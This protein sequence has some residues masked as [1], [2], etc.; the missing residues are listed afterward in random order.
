MN[1]TNLTCRLCGFRLSDL[2]ANLLLDKRFPGLFCPVCCH[3]LV[4]AFTHPPVF[5]DDFLNDFIIWDPAPEAA[6]AQPYPIVAGE[7]L[8][9]YVQG[10]RWNP[11]TELC[12]T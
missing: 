6:G 4:S 9:I 8:M 12:Y 7:K 2:R 11:Q 5:F 10:R 3:R 1:T